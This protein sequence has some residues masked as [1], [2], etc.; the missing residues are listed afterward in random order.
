M[1]P[2]P[3]SIQCLP[4]LHSMADPAPE[5]PAV[6]SPLCQLEPLPKLAAERQNRPK[7]ICKDYG[8][9]AILGG[10][11]DSPLKGCAFKASDVPLGVPGPLR[12]H[13]P[14]S[15]K[16]AARSCLI[17]Q[18]EPPIPGDEVIS[19]AFRRSPIPKMLCWVRTKIIPSRNSRRPCRPV[20]E[21]RCHQLK[22]P[23][24]L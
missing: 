8:L 1:V 21:I 18:R 3:S 14:C 22:F 5:I 20:H 17:L 23:G 4:A 15:H 7:K 16:N 19:A 6:W 10:L 13:Y 11:P 24:R 9:F 2:A 12:A